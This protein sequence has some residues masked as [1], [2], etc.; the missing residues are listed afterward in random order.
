MMLLISAA[1]YENLHFMNTKSK[2]KISCTVT[3]QLIS[4][5][6]FAL[7]IVQLLYLLNPKIEASSLSSVSTG[8]F[9]SDL[10]SKS[11]NRFAD[12]ATNTK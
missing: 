11:L 12:D 6:E 3:A 10:V 1:S 7:Q 8:Q 9:V 5:F 2:M 4:A